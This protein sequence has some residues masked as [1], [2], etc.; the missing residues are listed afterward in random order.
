MLADIATII[1][2]IFICAGL[3]WSWVR[4]LRQPYDT[5][6]ITMLVTNIGA[7]CLVFSTLIGIDVPLAEFGTFTVAAAV[8]MLTTAL[9]AAL[10]VRAAGLPLATFLPPLVFT[11]SGNMGLPLCLFAFGQTGLSFAIAYFTVSAVSH[12]TF[13][14]WLVSGHASPTILLKSPT[15]WAVAL[16]LVVLALDVSLPEWITNTTSLLGNFAIPLMLITLG[17]SLGRMAV[18]RPSRTV[19]LSALRL[20]LGFTV[21]WTVTGAFGFEGAAR[22]V[23]LIQSTMPVAVFNYLFSQ[24]YDRS[25]SEVASLVVTSTV[26][27]F[28]LLPG[29]IAVSLA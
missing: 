27:A 22:G 23:L 8:V 4:V 13:G 5:S 18:T 14:I 25:P 20:I 29:L 11:N 26:L 9:V 28:I 7:P 16:A 1:A 21:A 10:V 17:V 3:G 12:F 19:A 2:P 15:P 24:R 6:M